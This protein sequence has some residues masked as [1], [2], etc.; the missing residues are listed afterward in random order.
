MKYLYCLLFAFPFWASAQ[1]CDGTLGD[2]IFEAGDFGSGSANVLLPD[3]GIAPDYLYNLNPPPADG[4]YVVSNNTATWAALY[5]TWL[6]IGDNSSDP[7]GYMMIVNASF[8]PGLFYD[9]EIVDLCENTVYEFSADIINLIKIGVPDHIEPNVSFLI[10]G[11]VQFTTGNIPATEAWQTYG[12]TFNTAPGQTSLRLSLSNN[13]PGGNG[14]DLALD[15]ISFRTCGD[16][17]SILPDEPA[18]ICVDGQ[19]LPLTATVTGTQYDNPA[20]QWQISPNGIDNW[21]DIPGANSDTYIHN[22][23][24]IGEYF[25]RFQLANGPVNLMNEKCRINSNVKLVNVRPTEYVVTDTICTGLTYTVGNSLYTETGSFV[26]SLVNIYGCDSIIYT[27]LT[28]L[29]D[30]LMTAELSLSSP[31]CFN[32]AE[33]AISIDNV[34]NGTP[35]YSFLWNDGALGT[36][37]MIDQLA[38]D[39]SYDLLITDRY[40]CTADTSIFLPGPESL[41][42]DLGPNLDIL[43]GDEVNLTA[44]TGFTPANYV[45]LSTTDVLPCQSSPDCPSI[46]WFPT[47]SQTVYIT[48]TDASGCSV[49]DS[50]F[51]QVTPVYDLYIPNAFSPNRDGVNDYFTVYGPSQRI[52]RI[53]SFEVFNRWG[54]LLFQQADLPIGVGSAGWDGLVKGKIVD[55]GVYLYRIEVEFLDG[56]VR[57]YSGDVTVVR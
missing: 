45:W 7:N 53:A 13:A 19:P 21:T 17:A 52:N 12:F 46:S 51:I 55:Q 32:T 26:D 44:N 16:E 11:V 42:V 5:P 4:Q 36:G 27:D 54:Q 41:S 34:N 33:G 14:N 8:D 48:A 24:V 50:V 35:P 23:L 20:Y 2:N 3:P 6:A 25:Y 38:S 47:T 49:S 31:S 9:Q 1:T 18:N 28:V 22:I 15:N 40:G 30:P 37:T 29:P 57:E 56:S 39:N 10:D 43:L